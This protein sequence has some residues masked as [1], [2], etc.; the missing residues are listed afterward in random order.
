MHY[1]QAITGSNLSFKMVPIQAGE[2]TIGSAANEKGRN[3]DEGPQKKLIIAAFWMSA[4]EVTRDELDVF[5][6]DESTSLN[7]NVDAITR[8]SPQYVD[9]SLGMGKQGGY[10]ANSM[11]QRTAIMYC[12]W[13]Y[14]KTKVFYRLPTEAEWEYACKAGTNTAY[15]F[16]NNV[17]DLD[18]YAW[19]EK[20]SENTFH[21]V[22]KKLAN[23]WG[24]Y[25]MIGNMTEWT[26]D[27]YDAHAF[28]KINNEQLSIA[29]N[30]A[31]YPKTLKGG[32]F[33]DPAIELRSAKRFH[34]DPIWNRRDPQIPKSKW[35]LTEAKQVGIRLLRPFIQPS[36]EEINQFFKAYLNL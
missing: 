28:E 13:L 3:A 32:S 15:F 33:L 12:K 4:Y 10:P 29:A 1:D 23:P 19:Y 24:L 20:N 11:S 27:H 8:P 31:K 36:V 16:G 30:D 26:L 34:S 5:L 21:K 14:Q 9:L 18:K 7:V 22:G 2:F 25:D 35:W 17:A 6:K